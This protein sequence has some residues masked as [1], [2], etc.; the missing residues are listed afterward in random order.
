MCN[1]A[2]YSQKPNA[3]QQ[4]VAVAKLIC[5]YWFARCLQI[6]KSRAG[7][8]PGNGLTNGLHQLNLV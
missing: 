5:V 1:D 8:P 6:E 4:T 2:I 7:A 3:S